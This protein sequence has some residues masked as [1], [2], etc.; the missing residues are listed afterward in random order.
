[1]LP[2]HAIHTGAYLPYPHDTFT[3]AP[4]LCSAYALPTLRIAKHGVLRGE[5]SITGEHGATVAKHAGLALVAEQKSQLSI[6]LP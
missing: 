3:P 5:V 1:M 2:P 6:L 4:M